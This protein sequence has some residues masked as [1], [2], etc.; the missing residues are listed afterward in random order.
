MVRQ[1]AL[2]IC[3]APRSGRN[4]LVTASR[5]IS[6]NLLLHNRVQGSRPALH[7]DLENARDES[8]TKLM[9]NLRT[10]RR[11]GIQAFAA[12]GGERRSKTRST[13][14]PASLCP[15]CCNASSRASRAGSPS[16]QAIS[17]RVKAKRQTEQTLQQACR[18]IPG[19]SAPARP[20][21]SPSRVL[22]LVGDACEYGR[23]IAH[24]SSA[25]AASRCEQSQKPPHLVESGFDSNTATLAPV[26]FHTPSLLQ[27]IT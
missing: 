24:H 8:R 5:P 14:L 13:S 7:S 10:E 27:A 18:A 6:R 16:G 21:R 1:L 9:P 19:R 25:P 20:T 2:R 26:S 12:L 17:C 3:F 4:A 23:R 11:P 22:Q 15:T